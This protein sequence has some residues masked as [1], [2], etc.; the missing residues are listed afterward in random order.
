MTS[1][2]FMQAAIEEAQKGLAEGGIPIGSVLVIDGKIVGRGH[3]QRV[4]KGSCV[5]H[6]EMDCLENA[7]RLKAADYRR[8][9][10]YSTLS[11]CDM[12]SG[13]VLLYGIKKVV[14][15]ENRTFKGPEDYVRS[16][17]V[18]LD[19]RDNAQCIQLM[20]DFIA[21]QPALW[22]EDIGE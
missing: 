9:T 13:T 19:L 7:G 6:A 21:R 2:P 5:L 17:G 8:A 18:E 14:I 1:D 15:G 3:N 22:N 16:R 12:C 10:L 4:Q 11:P 20:Q